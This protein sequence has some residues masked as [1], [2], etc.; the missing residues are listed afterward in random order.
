MNTER[1]M[2]IKRGRPKMPETHIWNNRG[3]DGFCVTGETHCGQEAGPRLPLKR[4][5]GAKNAKQENSDLGS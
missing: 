1:K 5:D 4:L 3:A 2:L